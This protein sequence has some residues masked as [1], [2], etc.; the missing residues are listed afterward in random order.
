MSNST[1]TVRLHRVL[2]AP[3]ERVCDAHQGLIGQRAGMTHQPTPVDTSRQAQLG[4]MHEHWLAQDRAA[5]G[6]ASTS[7]ASPQDER[8]DGGD[9]FHGT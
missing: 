4:V 7:S 2:T 1:G 5:S 3:A 8:S 9:G 6:S